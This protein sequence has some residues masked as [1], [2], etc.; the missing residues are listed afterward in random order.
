MGVATPA[1]PAALT[2]MVMSRSVCVLCAFIAR[3]TCSAYDSAARSVC[4][5]RCRSVCLSHDAIGSELVREAIS[6][7]TKSEIIPAVFPVTKTE[8]RLNVS[9]SGIPGWLHVTQ[10]YR[11]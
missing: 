5:G 7:S 9:L 10:G 1:T 8:N 4:C 2:P 3:R 11:Q 6:L